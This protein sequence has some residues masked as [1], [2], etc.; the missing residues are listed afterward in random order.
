VRTVLSNDKI[1]AWPSSRTLPLRFREVAVRGVSLRKKRN[2]FLSRFV[3]TSFARQRVVERGAKV[4]RKIS[5]Q[6]AQCKKDLKRDQIQR[7]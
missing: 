1:Q 6:A 4:K 3:F 7:Y 5:A 2:K